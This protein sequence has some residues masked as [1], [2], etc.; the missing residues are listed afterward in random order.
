MVVVSMLGFN[1]VHCSFGE[2]LERERE[3][4]ITYD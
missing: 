4:D 1:V 2:E 3:R